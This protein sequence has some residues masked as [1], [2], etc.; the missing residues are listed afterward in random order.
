MMHDDTLLLGVDV[1]TTNCKAQVFDT[2]GRPCASGRAPTL[3][4]QPRPGRAEYDPEELWQTVVA[5]VRQAL[6]QVDPARVRGVAVAS[7]AEGGLLLDAAGRPLHPIIA[8]YDS[9]SDPQYRW[10]LDHVGADTFFPIAGNRPNPI[11]GVF[12]LM[13]LRDQAPQIYAAAARWLHVADYVAFRLCGAQA[14]DYSLATRTMLLDLPHRRWSGELIAAAGL[15]A[16]LL[17]EVVPAG[18]RIGVVT[19]A[20]AEATGLP[21]GIAVGNGGHDHPCG[22]LAA[23]AREEGI[24]LDS[25]G[26]AE[27]A[28]LPLDALRL[29]PQLAASRSS[30]GAHVARGRYYAAR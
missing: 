9:R 25:M 5:V 30:F 14:T 1:G 3:T 24:G 29:D 2:A 27:P 23:G 10:W 4:R 18:T 28:F 8:W 6:G 16:D 15:R 26:T 13:W 11:F 12:K 20:A 22:A 7:M 19:V 17:P 21:P